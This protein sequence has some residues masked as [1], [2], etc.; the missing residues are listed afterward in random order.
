MTVVVEG[1]TIEAVAI[2]MTGTEVA[3]EVHPGGSTEM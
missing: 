1:L 2:T 3:A